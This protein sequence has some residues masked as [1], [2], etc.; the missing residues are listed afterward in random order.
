M[1]F[2][3]RSRRQSILGALQ[4]HL[5]PPGCQKGFSCG[6][7][8]R[9]EFSTDFLHIHTKYAL[10]QGQDTNQFLT[11]WGSICGHQG[12]K[13]VCFLY[14]FSNS[15]HTFLRPRPLCQEIFGALQFHFWPL[16]GQVLFSCRCPT[17]LSSQMI[18]S[19]FA[20]N[21]HWTNLQN[22]VHFHLPLKTFVAT[23]G[24]SL[25]FLYVP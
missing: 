6:R 19:K 23:M 5:C 16:A 12:A 3:P 7:S 20:A 11:P 8:K 24:L 13:F 1:S 10:N 2:A 18:F 22:P 14:L 15:Q 25:F 21:I 9:P 17:T 4:F